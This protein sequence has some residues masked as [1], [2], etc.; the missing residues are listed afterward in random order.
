MCD[1]WG[2][3]LA[4]IPARGGSKGLPGKNILLLAGKPMICYTIDAARGVLPDADICV[5]SDSKEIIAIVEKY[6]LEVPFLRPEALS[7]DT[8]K[9]TDVLLHAL[10]FYEQRG[11]PYDT[12]LLLQP[13]SP[14]RHAEH[15]RQALEL[16]DGITDMVVSVKT[17]HSASVICRENNDGYL[18]LTLNKGA[19]RRQNLNYYEYNG[20]IYII[21]TASL[22]L[23]RKLT[24]KRIKKYVMDD[25]SSL[26][27]DDRLDYEFADMLMQKK[28]GSRG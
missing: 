9:T 8:A 21:R 11:C 27:I 20:A 25:L 13:T 16:Y 23:E 28:V 17:S 26:D 7:T 4:V 19:D 12:V 2:N 5:S 22:K 18:E 1:K 6:G 24:F 3:M 10:E 14:F 15:I